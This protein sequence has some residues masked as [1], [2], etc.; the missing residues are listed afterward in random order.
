LN[1]RQN[2]EFR[3]THNGIQDII[4]VTGEGIFWAIERR[5]E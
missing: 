2:E 1:I 4:Q 3:R 5:P